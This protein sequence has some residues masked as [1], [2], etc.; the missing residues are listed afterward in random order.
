MAFT[1]FHDDPDRITKQL[2]QQTDQERWYLDVPGNGGGEKPAF[3]LD[4]H[5]IPQKWGANLWTQSVD[6]NSSML[7]IDRRLNRDCIAAS[8]YKK[9]TIQTTAIQYPICDQFL[10]TEQSRAIMPAWTAKDL[11]QNHG[12][13]LP[14]NPQAHTELPFLN[15][16]STRIYEKDN[17]KRT[18]DCVVPNNDQRYTVPVANQKATYMGGPITCSASNNC[19]FVP[20]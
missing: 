13:I 11:Q 12:Y 5:I 2:Q 7:G 1:R 6:I 14:N 19:S 3:M 20:K 8:K 16:V 15:N 18:Y 9:Q 17:F 10:T 4:P